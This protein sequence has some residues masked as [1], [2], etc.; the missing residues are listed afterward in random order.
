M[1]EPKK[2]SLTEGVPPALLMNEKGQVLC[3]L[4]PEYEKELIAKIVEAIMKR[5]DGP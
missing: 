4:T 3:V 1:S 2:I 5:L